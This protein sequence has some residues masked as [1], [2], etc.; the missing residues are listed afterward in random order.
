[1]TLVRQLV[2]HVSPLQTAYCM[3]ERLLGLHCT[4]KVPAFECGTCIDP[5]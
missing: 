5:P 2:S 4:P 3:V 1:M